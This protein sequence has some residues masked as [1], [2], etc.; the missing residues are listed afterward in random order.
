MRI[1]VFVTPPNDADS[2]ADVF[3]VTFDALTL[4][5]TEVFPAGI[6]TE[7]GTVAE[8]EPLDSVTVSPPAGAAA[9]IL[10][11]PVADAPLL[12]VDGLTVAKPESAG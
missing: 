9:L 6:T 7:P 2:V 1:A 12:T 8:A 5:V 3:E 10:T 4:K 11:V